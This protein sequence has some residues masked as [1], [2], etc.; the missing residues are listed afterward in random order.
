MKLKIAKSQANDLTAEAHASLEQ[1]GK[2]ILDAYRRLLKKQK[3]QSLSRIQ[4]NWQCSIQERK[5]VDRIKYEVERSALLDRT[6][7]I[8]R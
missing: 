5:E 8:D 2:E 7:F 1:K 4:F 3:N 6:A